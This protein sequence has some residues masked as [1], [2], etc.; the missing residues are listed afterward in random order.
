MSFFKKEPE[1]KWPV[2]D[3]VCHDGDIFRDKH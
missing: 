1:I 2:P 3:P